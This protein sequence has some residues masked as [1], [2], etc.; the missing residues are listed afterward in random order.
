MPTG[1]Q[2]KLQEEMTALFQREI[3]AAICPSIW[4]TPTKGI[5]KALSKSLAVDKPFKRD[6]LSRDPSYSNTSLFP[7]VSHGHHS[8]PVSIQ[9]WIA[10]ICLREAISGTTPPYW[11]WTAICEHNIGKHFSIADITAAAVHHMMIQFRELTYKSCFHFSLAKNINLYI[12]AITIC[13]QTFCHWSFAWKNVM[14][15]KT[16][17]LIVGKRYCRLKSGN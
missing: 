7:W 1:K 5:S 10:S 16:D 2:P 4:F 3:A 14:E 13:K 9:N 17:F 12:K 11:E 8:T 15:F 6:R